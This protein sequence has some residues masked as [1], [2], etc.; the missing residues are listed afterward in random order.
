M[1]LPNYEGEEYIFL[2]FLSEILYFLTGPLE[3]GF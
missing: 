3:V 2:S 1:N